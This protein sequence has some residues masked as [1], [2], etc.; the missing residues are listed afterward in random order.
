[1]RSLSRTVAPLLLC[2][3]VC[4]NAQLPSARLFTI[5]PPGGKIGT[6]IEVEVTGQDLEGA[7]ELHFSDS[8]I[9]ATH[10]DGSKFKVNLPSDLDP[11]I[12]DVRVAGR[13]GISNPR[14]FALDAL[15][16]KVAPS[17]NS[18]PETAFQVEINSILNG[19]AVAEAF[20]FFKFALKKGQ[21]VLIDC[22][23]SQLDSR[24]NPSLVLLDGTG[25]ELSHK[26][27]GD[28]LDVQA[29]CDGEYILKL[30]DTLFRGGPE[31]FYRLIVSTRPHVDFSLPTAVP[32]GAKT[33]LTLY[34][35]NLPG[36]S[37]IT[38]FAATALEQLEVEVTAPSLLQADNGL[39]SSLQPA[40]ARLDG[41]AYRL[42]SSNGFSNP[43]FIGF[44]HASVTVEHEPNNK[45]QAAQRI[46]LPCSI[47]GQFYPANDQ[48]WYEFQARKGEVIWIEALSQRFGLPTSPF[49]VLQSVSTNST[50]DEK[51]TDIRE[52]SES[53]S[54]PDFK[55]PSL[56]PGWRFEVKDDGRYR[57]GVRDLFNSKADPRRVY[58]LSLRN[59]ESDFSLVIVPQ[60]SA[61]SKKD[62]KEAAIVAPFLR[63]GETIPLKIVALR[64][65]FKE[66]IELAVLGLPECLTA[67]PARIDS[68]TNSTLLFL[69]ASKDTAGWSGSVQIVG[70]ASTGAR[71]LVRQ[72]RFMTTS[73]N[74]PDTSVEPAQS[75]FTRDLTL[76]VSGQE[77]APVAIAATEEKTWEAAKGGKI[78]V[79]FAVERNG[80]FTAA[81][82]LKGTGVP[83]LPGKEIDFP[84]KSTNSMVELDLAKVQP[85]DYQ[86]VLQG[87]TQG[88]Y[89]PDLPKDAKP[90][91]VTLSVYS[92]PIRLRVA[93][94]ADK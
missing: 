54:F 20:Q 16:E 28:L 33:K 87:D 37:A 38:N 80:E 69:T 9:R 53:E 77:I 5:F 23:T 12:C 1:V 14:A 83:G 26:S 66:P 21:R 19:R 71:Q 39:A 44:T 6:T 68:S 10:L 85:G 29:P 3:P 67:A 90:K 25:H 58:A 42:H 41:F 60:P 51:L 30:H 84:A 55:M 56:D 92:K 24:L 82:K 8:R 7:Q 4:V 43:L 13:F 94:A 34:G 79:P 17:T 73:W 62:S 91:D 40:A 63:K 88:K 2:L 78:K 15:P 49:V 47:S 89:K 31:Y 93:P 65:Q 36:G 32:T 61:P 18:S 50:G 75:R 35:R 70:N 76:A 86:L 22:Q 81:L 72:A 64:H 74:V 52:I 59:D 11:E 48:D 45:P 57:L 46:H 27:A